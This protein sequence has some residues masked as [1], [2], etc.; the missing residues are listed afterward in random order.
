MSRKLEIELEKR[1][2]EKVVDCLLKAGFS[3]SVNDGENLVLG[4][5]IDKQEIMRAVFSTDEDILIAHKE[6]EADKFIYFM[7]GSGESVIHDYSTILE[8]I[9]KEAL[10]FAESYAD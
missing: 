3:V 6:R 7:W 8:P 2:C 4:E 9:I 1:I 10:D 5:S